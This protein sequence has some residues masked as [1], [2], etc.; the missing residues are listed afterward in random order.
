MRFLG[1]KC[2]KNASASLPAAGAYSAPPDT[3][4]GFKVPTS[5]GR[6]GREGQGEEREGKGRGREGKS[7]RRKGEGKGE[8]HTC[9]SSRDT[10]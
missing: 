4:A 9:T 7:G 6:E 10:D 1:A 8:S 5:K 3:L 2:A